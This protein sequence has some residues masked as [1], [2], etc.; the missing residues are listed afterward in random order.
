M[1]RTGYDVRETDPFEPKR[2]SGALDWA[3]APIVGRLHSLWE[4]MRE[5]VIAAFPEAPGLPEKP[6][7]YLSFVD[8]TAT[9]ALRALS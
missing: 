1:K 8:D 3:Q 5:P 9:D 6:E 7:A 2:V 4:M